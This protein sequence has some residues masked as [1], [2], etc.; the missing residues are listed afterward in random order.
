MTQP[1]SRDETTDL[2]NNITVTGIL[3]AEKRVGGVCSSCS[4]LSTH[5]I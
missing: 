1:Q 4:T 5:A 2:P 3:A